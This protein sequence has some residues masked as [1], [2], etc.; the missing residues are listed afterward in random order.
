[1]EIKKGERS[2]VS[3]RR[4]VPQHRRGEY[5]ELWAALHAA[6]SDRGAHA[7]HFLSTET[8]GVFLEFLEFGPE[9]D[10]R[11]DSEVLEAI[12]QLHNEF[13]LPYPTP[14]TL[15]EWVEITA[16]SREAL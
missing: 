5:A 12:R 6:A 7:W 13:G 2:L 3:I 9:S 10:V 8:P 1:M 15:E 14:N 11:S 4:F 16:P